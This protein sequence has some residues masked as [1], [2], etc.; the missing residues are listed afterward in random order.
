[1]RS[2]YF[3]VL[4]V[5]GAANNATLHKLRLHKLTLHKLMLHKHPR[6]TNA[7]KIIAFLQRANKIGK[8]RPYIPQSANKIGRNYTLSCTNYI[9]SH[10]ISVRNA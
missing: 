6:K 7:R 1:M 2:L 5:T 9:Q 8:A 10:E 4:A 3:P